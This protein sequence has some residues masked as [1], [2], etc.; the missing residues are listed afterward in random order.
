MKVGAKKSNKKEGNVISY[1]YRVITAT[2]PNG[3][4][5]RAHVM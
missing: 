5:N 1:L 4:P 3:Q 2:R